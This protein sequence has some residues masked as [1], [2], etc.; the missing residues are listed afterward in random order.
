MK[1]RVRSIIAGY[2]ALLFLL[3]WYGHAQAATRD[4]R[5]TWDANPPDEQVDRYVLRIFDAS[6]DLASHET[7]GVEQ[8]FS[9][10][11]PVDSRFS[12]TVKACRAAE[13]SEESS[14]VE[15][16]VPVD[17]LTIPGNLRVQVQVR[18]EVNVGGEP[19]P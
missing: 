16:T 6:G 9:L 10:D 11:L 2:F 8:A 5:A 13:C 14:P 3:I 17:A 1:I 19:A 7:P 15:V 4:Y 18:V 12:V